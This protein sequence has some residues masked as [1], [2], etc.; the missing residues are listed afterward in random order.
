MLSVLQV[1]IAVALIAVL[2]VLGTGLVSMLR[3][4][5][6]NKKYGNILMRARIATQAVAILLIFAYY[7]STRTD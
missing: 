5:D 6:F 4:G 7:L 1:L 2:A 3:G